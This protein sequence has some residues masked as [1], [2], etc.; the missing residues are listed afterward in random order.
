MKKYLILAAAT[1][2]SGCSMWNDW[3]WNWNALNPWADDEAAVQSA[4][5][6]T[7][8]E[9]PA[10]VN[11]Y[12]WQASLDK[13]AFMGIESRRPDAGQIITGWKTFPAAPNERFKIMAEI[14]SGE[15]RADAL[16][17]KVYKEAKTRR[18]NWIKTAPSDALTGELEQAVITQAKIL[19]IND[20]NKE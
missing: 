7:K 13:L 1:V 19:Y 14:N 17:I 3:D 16:D 8:T 11:K 9:L 18:G 5:E 15:L 12:L 6:Q 2:L 20:K 4:E 10:T